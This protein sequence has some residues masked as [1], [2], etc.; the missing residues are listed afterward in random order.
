LSVVVVSMRRNRGQAALAL[1]IVLTIFVVGTL[2]MV[3]YEISRILLA[4]EQL[5]NCLEMASLAGGA[6][7]ASSNATGSAAQN[8][9]KTV[10]MNLLQM[11]SVLGSSLHGNVT[12]GSSATALNPEC[13]NNFETQFLKDLYREAK[14]IFADFQALRVPHNA[15]RAFHY[16][17]NAHRMDDFEIAVTN[18]I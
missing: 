4:R 7:M 15:L 13:V 12:I 9:S 8:E 17:E 11:N 10:A 3:T 18:I 14:T 6:A 5:R 16:F 2:G 1:N